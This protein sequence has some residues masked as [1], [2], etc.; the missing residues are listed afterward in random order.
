MEQDVA[1][2]L[3]LHNIKEYVQLSEGKAKQLMET[4]IWCLRYCKHTY[5]VKLKVEDENNTY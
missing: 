5:G 4:C 3:N 2:E 1:P